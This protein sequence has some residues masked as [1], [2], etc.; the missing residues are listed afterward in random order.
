V[1]SDLTHLPSV[2]S[3]KIGLGTRD[4]SLEPAMTHDEAIRGVM[5]GVEVLERHGAKA[6]IVAVGEMGIGN[7]T[8]ASAVTACLTGARVEQVVGPGT[9]LDDERIVHKTEIVQQGV[10]RVEDRSDA[11]LVLTEVGGFEIAGMVGVMIAAARAGKV[12][13]VDGFIS[14]AAALIAARLCPA[15][16]DFFVASHR[17][18]EPGHQLA[19]ETLGLSPILDLQLRLGEAS[20]AALVLPIIHAA[21]A[22]LREMATFESAGVSNRATD[23]GDT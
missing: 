17:S 22:I 20:G 15:I 12:I 18:P 10:S 5:V 3:H 6:D 14:T 19:L 23:E 8:A 11:L 21:A 16:T 7:T 9:G 1:A 2:L 13:V 4:L